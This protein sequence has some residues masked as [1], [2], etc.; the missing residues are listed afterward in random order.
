MP[1]NEDQ[2]QQQGFVSSLVTTKN[3]ILII[4]AI[5]TGW[6]TYW[7]QR[8]KN[9]LE[10]TKAQLD[11]AKA[12]L[13]IQSIIL[14]NQSAELESD[15]RKR[16]FGNDLKFKLY[17]EV[18]DAI[19]KRE[20][21][22]QDAVVLIINEMLA[23]DSLYRAKLSNILLSSQNTDAAVKTSIVQTQKLEYTFVAEQTQTQ[24]TLNL[25]KNEDKYTIDV[26]YLEDVKQEAQPRAEKIVKLLEAKY[27]QH[28]VRLRMLPKIINARSGYGVGSNQVRYEPGE[29]KLADEVIGYITGEKVFPREQLTGHPVKNKTA[30]YISIF[31]RNM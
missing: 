4:L 8:T 11:T 31:V 3:V 16:E 9:S 10:V 20:S 2:P 1:E 25:S 12:R 22:I 5:L 13:E 7:T 19:T 30:H 29:K 23:D 18:K 27:P 15:I 14:A 21:K 6:N 26:F 17:E 24:A 28:T